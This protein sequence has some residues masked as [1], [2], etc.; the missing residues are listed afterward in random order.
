[1]KMHGVLKGG[2]F[3]KI[4][5]QLFEL[6]RSRKYRYQDGTKL[7]S[8]QEAREFVEQSG[9]VMLFG[10]KDIDLPSL[11]DATFDTQNFK[12][13]WWGWKDRLS[14]AKEVFYGRLVQKKATLSSWDLFECFFALSGSSGELDEYLYEYKH[15]RMG[16]TA[17]N[18]Y[19]HLLKFG[20]TPTDVLRDA[21]KM[22]D[23]RMKSHFEKA[24]I[25][26]QLQFR[27]AKVGSE[28]RRWGVDVWDILPRWIPERIE[29]ALMLQSSDARI[30]IAR[31]YLETV[32]V[33]TEARMGKLF[34]WDKGQVSHIVSTLK[35]SGELIDDIEFSDELSPAIGWASF[36]AGLQE[37]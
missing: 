8:Q 9:L 3:V 16:A 24:L 29:S 7:K 31:R 30:G 5:E 23:K 26:L 4:K 25:D 10:C 6:N 33:T 17:K 14:Q 15:G 21:V 28:N 34:G 13:T 36:I 20:P 32:G 22:S 11:Y 12:D 19:E 35:E 1:M 2:C 37:V 18:I 27:I